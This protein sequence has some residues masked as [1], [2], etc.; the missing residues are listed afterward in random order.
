MAP[1]SDYYYHCKVKK[2][3]SR[4]LQLYLIFMY[5][6]IEPK[7]TLF[8]FNKWVKRMIKGIK[9]K[10]YN[11]A[12]NILVVDDEDHVGLFIEVLLNSR[13]YNIT[14][15]SNAQHALEHFE[16]DSQSFDLVITDQNM[17]IMSGSE[18]SK[19]LLGVR[20]DIPIILC[21]GHS[22]EHI[23]DMTKDI[24]IH[25]Y[26]PKPLRANELLDCVAELYQQAC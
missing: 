8:N 24:A 14:R 3:L 15:F 4:T 20:P 7:K 2:I 10:G 12:L 13:G 5:K 6:N 26:L 19:S 23:A 1:H 22:Y 11:Q 25:A 17:P 16:T 9:H 21:T 18:L